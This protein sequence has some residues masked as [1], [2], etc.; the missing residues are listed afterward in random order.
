MRARTYR[1]ANAQMRQLGFARTDLLLHVTYDAS[2]DGDATEFARKILEA[3]APVMFNQKARPIFAT[4]ALDEAR[5]KQLI[6][7]SE[8]LVERA[9]KPPQPR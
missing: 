5:V 4:P 9:L 8:A 3:H 1:A 7:E 2:R 6:S